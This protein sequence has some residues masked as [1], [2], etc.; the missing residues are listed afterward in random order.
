MATNLTYDG[1]RSIAAR[2][3]IAAVFFV[4]GA[5][6]SSWLPRLPEL[7]ERLGI[8][9]AALG[10]TLVGSGVG[11]LAASAWSGWLVDR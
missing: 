8:S 3:A 2:N 9:D 1:G 5:T 4:N 10:V 11:G 6:F 7:Q